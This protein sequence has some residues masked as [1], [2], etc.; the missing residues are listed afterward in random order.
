MID[1]T[2]PQRYSYS[3][4]GE[5]IFLYHIF[6]RIGT[7]NK[8]SVEF[9]GSNGYGCSN[10]RFFVNEEGWTG[11]FWDIDPKGDDVK[12]EKITMEN[13]NSIFKKYKI[14]QNLDLLS[15]DIDGNDYWVWKALKWSPR[16]L[17][18]EFNPS[19][20]KNKA[21]AIKYNPDIEFKQ[22]N[23]YGAS[24]AALKKLSDAKGY[25]LIMC[26]GC[27]MIFIKKSIKYSHTTYRNKGGWPRDK[28]RKDDWIEV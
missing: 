10:T 25:K 9:G 8:V 12:K 1:R 5:D 4:A 24:W 15:I 27:N 16:V 6:K 23:Y 28:Q 11:H 18:I 2:K 20:P 7:T 21:M 17:I 3:Q 22:T 14:P 19:W 13:V 26:M